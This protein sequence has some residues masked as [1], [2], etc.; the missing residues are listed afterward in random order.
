[1]QPE[2]NRDRPFQEGTQPTERK[3][4]TLPANPARTQSRCQASPPED[5]SS[6]LDRLIE[7]VGKLAIPGRFAANAALVRAEIET[8]GRTDDAA[9]AGAKGDAR[10]PGGRR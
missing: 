6:E 1:M 10:L 7:A 2:D 3:G 9:S 4:F 5:A 8:I